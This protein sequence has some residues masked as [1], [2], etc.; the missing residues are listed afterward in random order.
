[1]CTKPGLHAHLGWL[2]D[3]TVQISCLPVTG[4]EKGK[5]CVREFRQRTN[6]E[7]WNALRFNNKTSQNVPLQGGKPLQASTVGLVQPQ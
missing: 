3:V 7:V 5:Y 2:P 6:Q 1:M 4:V